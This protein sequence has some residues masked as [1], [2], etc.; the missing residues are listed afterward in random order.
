[1]GKDDLGSLFESFER[2]KAAADEIDHD[3]V[4]AREHSIAQQLQ[5]MGGMIV[6]IT[7]PDVV[8]SA[9]SYKKLGEKVDLSQ[10]DR[11]L[12]VPRQRRLILGKAA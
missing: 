6:A 3:A 1:M 10:V 7:G 11:T 12:Q 2:M 8:A 4:S 9:K 5:G